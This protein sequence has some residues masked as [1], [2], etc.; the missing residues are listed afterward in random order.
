MRYE[1]STPK[2]M[3]AVSTWYEGDYFYIQCA[4][5]GMFRKVNLHT[6]EMTVISVGDMWATHAGMTFMTQTPESLN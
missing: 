2:T 3:H 4:T 6:Q 1:F 5:C